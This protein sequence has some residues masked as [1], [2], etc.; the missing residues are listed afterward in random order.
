MQFLTNLVKL[1]DYPFVYSLV[2]LLL[3]MSGHRINLDSV[4][5]STIGP[6]ITIIG[7][8]ATILSIGD[9]FGNLLRFGIKRARP[10]REDYLS[11]DEQR[12]R[13]MAEKASKTNWISYE[14]DKMVSTVFLVTSLAQV[15]NVNI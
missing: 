12:Y 13:D 6:L 10:E 11:I 14:I 9:P 7:L 3:A 8:F 15:V 2:G 5:F 4:S 1:T